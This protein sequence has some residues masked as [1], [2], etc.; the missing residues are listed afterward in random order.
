M[1]FV[2]WIHQ[3]GLR[4]IQC[5]NTSTEDFKEDGEALAQFVRTHTLA[6]LDE[7]HEILGCIRWKPWANDQGELKVTK[8][9]TTQE[10]ADV[11]V[12]LGNLCWAL[13]IDGV[14]ISAALRQADVKIRERASRPEGYSAR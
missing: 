4:Q 1:D 12:F 3:C 10:I 8:W 7:V 9:E 13:G 6:A 2:D 14:D 11:L 5:F